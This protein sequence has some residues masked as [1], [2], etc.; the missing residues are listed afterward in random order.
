MVGTGDRQNMATYL[1]DTY[2]ISITRACKVI[3]LPKS[4]FYYQSVKDDTEVIKKLLEM[5]ALRPREGQDKIYQR[6]RLEGYGWNKKRVRRIYLKL[7]LN[8]R[9][10]TKKRI[11]ARVKEPLVQVEQPNQTW[12]MDF[13]SD[14]LTS[15][16][17]FRTLN[18]IDDYNRRAL[19]VCPDFSI[20]SEKDGFNHIYIRGLDGSEEQITKG[21]WEV[22]SFH[23][24]DSDKMEI[25][26]TSTEDGSINR[27]LYVQNLETDVKTKL[28]TVNGT[29]NSSFSN[30]LKY[31]M[32]SVSTAN[33]APIF[34]LHNAEGKQLKVLEDNVKFNTEIKELNEQIS[35]QKTAIEKHCPIIYSSLDTIEACGG[36]VH[37]RNRPGGGL[38]YFLRLP[39]VD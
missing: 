10:K 31:Y 19:L 26:Y 28:S 29:N 4:M 5:V 2:M 35:K 32:N 36:E 39:A 30:G 13:M 27:S 15:G 22:T 20:S 25:Y 23:G 1:R 12:S 16:L 34:T 24:V 3:R 6:L 17:R 38:K 9:R 11:P 8:L 33:S 37:C 14:A 21:N 7:G 18:V